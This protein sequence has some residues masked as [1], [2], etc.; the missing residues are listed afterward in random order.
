MILVHGVVPGPERHGW[1]LLLVEPGQR[2]RWL[3]AG[4]DDLADVGDVASATA[5]RVGGRLMSVVERPA[6]YI[7]EHARGAQLLATAFAAGALWHK[8]GGRSLLGPCAQIAPERWRS[9]VCGKPT[10]SDA[11]VKRALGIHL[12]LPARS[13]AHERDACGVALGWALL[14]GIVVGGRGRTDP[15][16]APGRVAP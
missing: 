7:H 13:N 11:D 15:S 8:L 1:C 2:P 14:A 12:T 5:E 9:V 10:P 6:G 4:H 3:A 16:P